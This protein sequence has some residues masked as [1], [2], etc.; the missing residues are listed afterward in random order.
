VLLSTH[1]DRQGVDISV[2]VC[3]FV[4]LFVRL[5]IS[6]ARINLAA[7]N[8]ARRFIGVQGRESPILGNFAPT[9]PKSACG[10]ATARTGLKIKRSI[11]SIVEM[12]RRNRHAK[13]APFVEYRAACGHR[14]GMCG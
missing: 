13:D 9:S 3:V 1:D 12:R 4:C 11:Y 10:S 5:R 8:F 7:S 6:P 14:I 2:T